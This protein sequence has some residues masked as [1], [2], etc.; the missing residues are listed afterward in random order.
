MPIRILSTVLTLALIASIALTV[1]IAGFAL[2][3][4]LVG[5]TL[6]TG[7]AV[8]AGDEF[9][10]V[11]PLPAADSAG[12]MTL[13]IDRGDL[14]LPF[15]TFAANVFRVI[16]VVA[17]GG[18]W[19]AVIFLL[20]RF[21]RE[22]ASARPFSRASVRLL[23]LSGLLMLVFPVWQGVR[24]LVW[25]GLVLAHHDD[26]LLVHSFARTPEGGALRLLP[27]L[28]PAVAIAGLVLLVV[29]RAFRTGVEVQRDSDEVV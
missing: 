28:D 25:Q 8:A 20:R 4:P 17:T 26:G 11:I 23:S 9:A 5:Q 2:V 13:R 24:S 18:F 10:R 27:D 12:E 3:A 29:A 6:D 14:V 19:I 16:D 1:L 21:C 15:G 22:A 7:F